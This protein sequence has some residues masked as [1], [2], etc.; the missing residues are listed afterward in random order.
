MTSLPLAIR[1]APDAHTTSAV[2][3]ALAGRLDRLAGRLDSDTAPELERALQP[4]VGGDIAELTFLS[5]AGIRVLVAA[6]KGLRARGGTLV[7]SRAQP[8]VATVLGIVMAL[9]DLM[10]FEDDRELD[11]YLAEVQAKTLD[12]RRHKSGA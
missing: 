7:L 5:S 12:A 2:R 8:Q 11:R 3:V 4:L 6:R 9:P 10:L 1:V